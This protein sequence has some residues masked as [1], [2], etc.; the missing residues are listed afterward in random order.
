MYGYQQ[1]AIDIYKEGLS[2][3]ISSTTDRPPTAA[4]ASITNVNDRQQRQILGL[5][6]EEKN[7][8]ILQEKR[9]DF[10]FWKTFSTA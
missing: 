10:F 9:I 5:I 6:N 2:R 7:A 4:V 8:A 1:K 3:Q